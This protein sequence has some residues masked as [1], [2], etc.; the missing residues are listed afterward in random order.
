VTCS[1]GLDRFEAQQD[2]VH[3]VLARSRLALFKAKS[4][5][6][7]SNSIF[8]TDLEEHAVS[9]RKL[10]TDIQNGLD[11]HA[12]VP[13]FQPQ[14]DTETRKMVGLEVLAR[15][16]HPER[17]LL[18]PKSFLETASQMKA[19]QEI[20][21]SVFQ[22]SIAT[23]RGWKM[24]LGRDVALS[25]NISVERLIDPAL[26]ADLR[27]L[28]A[29]AKLITLEIVDT[30]YRNHPAHSFS[31]V[32]NRL[33]RTGVGI[34]VDDFGSDRTSVLAL[35][36]IRPDQLKI[37]KHLVEPVTR[38]SEARDLLR[39]ILK[40]STLRFCT[41]WGATVYKASISDARCPQMK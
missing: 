36:A 19:L 33:R 22:Q 5:K 40:M 34:D 16:D 10:E 11:D 37:Q 29:A 21:G 8:S 2:T 9:R 1:I 3:S 17:G 35:A 25:L 41:N 18:A 26:I 20:D 39:S 13:Y 7:G 27:Q 23:Q 31:S 32:I 24:A 6:R 14:I 28:G 38:Q 15:W 12:F 30:V 4:A